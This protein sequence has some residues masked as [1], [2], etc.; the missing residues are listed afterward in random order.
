M[1]TLIGCECEAVKLCLQITLFPRQFYVRDLYTFF[2]PEQICGLSQ[3]MSI[4]C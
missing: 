1:D 2:F 3:D 4:K